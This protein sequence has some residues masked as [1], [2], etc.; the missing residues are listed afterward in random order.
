MKNLCYELSNSIVI[1][2]DNN[3]IQNNVQ[4][5]SEISDLLMVSKA[6]YDSAAQQS[7]PIHIYVRL[8]N[9][10]KSYNSYTNDDLHVF[11]YIMLRMGGRVV[12]CRLSP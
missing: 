3:A 12:V 2:K 9:T 6:F 4:Y 1:V 10:Y 8:Y 5:K 7:V 11:L